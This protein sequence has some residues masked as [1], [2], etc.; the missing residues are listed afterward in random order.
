VF[1]NRRNKQQSQRCCECLRLH[2]AYYV[3]PWRTELRVLAG[4][5]PDAIFAYFGS[6]ILGLPPRAAT[7]AVATTTWQL[8]DAAGYTISAGTTIAVTPPASRDSYAFTVDADI[9]VP[10]GESIVRSVNCHALLAGAAASGLTGTVAV[11]DPLTF[12][13]TVTLDSPTSGGVDAETSSEYLSRLSALLT[14]LTP[15]PILPQDFA[16]LA[17]RSVPEVARAVAVDLYNAET[18]ATGV[19]RCVTVIGVDAAG[20]ALSSS[21]KAEVDA[22]LQAMREVNFLVFVDDASY[23]AISV[24][25]DVQ[26]YP[27]TDPAEISSRVIA[28]LTGY[29]Q[30]ANWGVPPYGDTSARSWINQTT[31]R[32]LELAEQVNRTDGV[33]YVNSL[34]FGVTG[35]PLGQTDV[36]LDGPAA[37]TQPGAILC[38]AH[39]ET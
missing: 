13:A 32:Y 12:V 8:H 23:T 15:R 22:L 31:V 11:I 39:A 17:Q 28:K 7:R 36:V 10:V 33:H 3:C 6:S 38:S 1:R 30:P 27:G 37:L 19:P 24:T 29:L 34:S 16:V 5:V 21:V 18:G 35:G 25:C 26:S 20:G 9:T 2:G 14:L 4:L